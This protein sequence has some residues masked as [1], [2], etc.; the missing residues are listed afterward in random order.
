MAVSLAECDEMIAACKAA[1]VRLAVNHQMR[2]MDQYVLPKRIVQSEAIGGLTS[3]NVVAGNFGMAMNGS[4]YFEMARYMTDEM[5]VEVSAWFSSETVPNPRGAEFEDRAGCV[6]VVTAGG[7][8][9]YMDASSDQGFGMHVSYGGRFGRVDVDELAG[10]MRTVARARCC[11][12]C[13]PPT[14]IPTAR[15]DAWRSRC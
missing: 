6:R 4:H 12:R 10:R 13:W 2:F 3:I 5:P 9:F 8:R 1:G 11:R 15:S 14:T 7:K